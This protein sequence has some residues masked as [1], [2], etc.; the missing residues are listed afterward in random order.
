MKQSV[1]IVDITL[2]VF[3]YRHSQLDWESTTCF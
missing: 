1:S 2:Y 3:S